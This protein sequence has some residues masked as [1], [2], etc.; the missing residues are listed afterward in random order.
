LDAVTNAIIE[1]DTLGILARE[2]VDLATRWGMPYDGN[3]I[4]YAFQI[5]RNY[6]GAHSK[7]GDTWV[8]SASSDQSQLAVYGARRTSDTKYTILVLNKTAAALTSSLTLS[9]IST[10]APAQ[11]WLWTGGT[12]SPTGSTPIH[13][14]VITATYPPKSMTLYVVG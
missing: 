6:D 7:F 5:F 9:G 4:G 14:G 10:T 11:T 12:I 8:H 13:S 3:L 2:G 1:A